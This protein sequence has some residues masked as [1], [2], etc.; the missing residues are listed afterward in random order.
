MPTPADSRRLLEPGHPPAGPVASPLAVAAGTRV[1]ARL[2]TLNFLLAL[3]KFRKLLDWVSPKP[4]RGPSARSDARS[5]DCRLLQ[6]CTRPFKFQAHI[7]VPTVTRPRRPRR[8]RAAASASA[9]PCSLESAAN[10][11]LG[12]RT[13]RASRTEGPSSTAWLGI[14]RFVC[15]PYVNRA[16]FGISTSAVACGSCQ[17]SG[18]PCPSASIS[19]IKIWIRQL[20]KFRVFLIRELVQG[21]S[22][23][24][25][26]TPSS[27]PSR[28]TLGCRTCAGRRRRARPSRR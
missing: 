18:C 20:R 11:G 28:R 3:G 24:G 23:L 16:L 27:E 4:R 7:Q 26:C 5:C 8:P 1:Y 22:G 10:A 19:S 2:E 14:A 9:A 12:S 6:S 21:W 17:L 15:F 25:R 13:A